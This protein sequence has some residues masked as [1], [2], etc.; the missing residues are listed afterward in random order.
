MGEIWASER[1]MAPGVW[2]ALGVYHCPHSDGTPSL[3][4]DVVGTHATACN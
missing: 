3:A 4:V 1:E 2:A